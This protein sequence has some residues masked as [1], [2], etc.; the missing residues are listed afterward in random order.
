[1]IKPSYRGKRWTQDRDDA[2]NRISNTLEEEIEA[3]VNDAIQDYIDS[4][5]FEEDASDY[6][7]EAGWKEPQ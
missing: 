1:M 7:R 3:L 6:C 4:N 5:Q 2:I